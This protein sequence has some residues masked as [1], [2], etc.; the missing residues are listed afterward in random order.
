MFQQ[1]K[2]ESK[3]ICWYF[4][5]KLKVKIQNIEKCL[6]NLA[7]AFIIISIQNGVCFWWHCETHAEQ[8]VL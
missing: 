7:M 5:L 2:S 6:L 1:A 8:V 3:K 4:M